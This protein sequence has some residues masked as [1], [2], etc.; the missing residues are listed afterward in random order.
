VIQ[1]LGGKSKGKVNG[2]RIRMR[3][4]IGVGENDWKIRGVP[5]EHQHTPQREGPGP[6]LQ[7]YRA[8]E[9]IRLYVV[10]DQLIRLELHSKRSR[11]ALQQ[12]ITISGFFVVHGTCSFDSCDSLH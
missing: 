8:I 2:D 5:E 10:T 4:L 6:A 1:S 11:G 3:R 7:C 9:V 12:L